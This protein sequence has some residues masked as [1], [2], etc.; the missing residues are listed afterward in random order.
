MMRVLKVVEEMGD[1]FD[2]LQ[3]KAEACIKRGFD[4]FEKINLDIYG[5]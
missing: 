5:I 1:N 4:N 2:N 3:R